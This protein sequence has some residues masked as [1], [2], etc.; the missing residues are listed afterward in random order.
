MGRQ[1]NFPLQLSATA[2]Q[3]FLATAA[4]G[5][6]RDDDASVARMIAG[7]TGVALPQPKTKDGS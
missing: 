4:A 7:L 2:L 5:M 1:E 3:M 6:G